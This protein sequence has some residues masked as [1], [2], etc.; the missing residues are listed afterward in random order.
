M[1]YL[2]VS[3]PELCTLTYFEGP[4]DQRMIISNIRAKDISILSDVMRYRVFSIDNNVLVNK[5]Q[6]PTNIYCLNLL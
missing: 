4:H 2:I 5:T 6:L 3:I 1:W